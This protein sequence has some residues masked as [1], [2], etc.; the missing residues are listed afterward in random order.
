MMFVTSKHVFKIKKNVVIFLKI[1]I[2]LLLPRPFNRFGVSLLQIDGLTVTA[3]FLVFFFAKWHWVFGVRHVRVLVLITERA[4]LGLTFQL[5]ICTVSICS[6]H[7]VQMQGKER[8]PENSDVIKFCQFAFVIYSKLCV[9]I[10]W[11]FHSQDFHMNSP[12]C[13]TFPI[14][15]VLITWC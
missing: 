10:S 6:I 5:F 12:V 14:L 2:Y 11:P 1:T 8:H 3:F 7:F 9:D 15:L 4:F 13:H